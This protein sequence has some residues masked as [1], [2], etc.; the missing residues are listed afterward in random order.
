LAFEGLAIDISVVGNSGKTVL[1]PVRI[2][3]TEAVKRVSRFLQSN[4]IEPQKKDTSC[5]LM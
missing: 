2:E 3:G 4:N 5:V 1:D